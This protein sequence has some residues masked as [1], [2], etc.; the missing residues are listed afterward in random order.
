MK[1]PN[2]IAMQSY[3][4]AFPVDVHS[5][6]ATRSRGTSSLSQ[7]A[8]CAQNRLPR[9]QPAPA[10][11]SEPTAIALRSPYGLANVPPDAPTLTP[12]AHQR[13]H[14]THSRPRTPKKTSLSRATRSRPCPIQPHTRPTSSPRLHHFSPPIRP[15]PAISPPLLKYKHKRATLAHARN[16]PRGPETLPSNGV[17]P[18]TSVG[19]SQRSARNRG[20][21][22]KAPG[23]CRGVPCGRPVAV[24]TRLSDPAQS[25]CPPLPRG[26]TF[27]SRQPAPALQI[28]AGP[29]TPSATRRTECRRNEQTSPSREACPRGSMP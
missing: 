20:T 22:P 26:A 11:N 23:I 5:V 15:D 14:P 12:A 9:E 21:P 10:P 2:V 4:V 13:P 29:A 18:Q 24:K 8:R 19:A 6:S 27:V 1:Y 7:I 25:P 17:R 16:R 28:R 3:I